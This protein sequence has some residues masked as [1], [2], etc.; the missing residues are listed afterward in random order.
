MQL[1]RRLANRLSQLIAND[2]SWIKERR[3][4]C[5]RVR[6]L[7]CDGWD[8]HSE[9]A[10]ISLALEPECVMHCFV[11]QRTGNVSMGV[12]LGTDEVWS[13]IVWGF[14]F[15]FP[16]KKSKIILVLQPDMLQPLGFASKTIWKLHRDGESWLMGTE[17]WFLASGDS[18]SH[19]DAQNPPLHTRKHPWQHQT[20]VDDLFGYKN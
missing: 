18:N 4:S 16:L 7:H 12:T 5:P 19:G 10:R 17:S 1:V 9:V 13:K 15:L 8:S 11:L 3:E 14:F 2:C 6:L 20:G